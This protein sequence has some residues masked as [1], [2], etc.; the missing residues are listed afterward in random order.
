[1][2]N[3]LNLNELIKSTELKELNELQ[4]DELELDEFDI[5]D[6]TLTDSIDENFKNIIYSHPFYSEDNLDYEYRVTFE[7]DILHLDEIKYDDNS[8]FDDCVTILSNVIIKP[9]N[10]IKELINNNIDI[11]NGNPILD[12]NNDIMTLIDKN[13]TNFEAELENN[14]LVILLD[15]YKDLKETLIF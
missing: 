6:M 8:N 9:I 2:S 13:S 7:N 1:M 5:N 11:R 3:E 12:I 10:E 4:L 15:L 14:K